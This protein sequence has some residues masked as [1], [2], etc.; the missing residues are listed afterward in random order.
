M[1]E[2]N[3]NEPFDWDIERVVK[4]L[5]TPERTWDAPA[6]HKL[7]DPER[8]A[9][10]LRDLGVDGETL[11]TYADE[12]GWSTFWETLGIKRAAHH[13]SISKAIKHFRERSAKYYRQKREIDLPTCP[14]SATPAIKPDPLNHSEPTPLVDRCIP[15]PTTAAIDGL[16]SEPS[17]AEVDSAVTEASPATVGNVATEASP[18]T[19]NSTSAEASPAVLN[20]AT[21]EPTA[22]VVSRPP[23]ETAPVVTDSPAVAPTPMEGVISQHAAPTEQ[24]QDVQM[25]CIPDQPPGS[26]EQRVLDSGLRQDTEEPS[27]DSERPPKRRR[28]APTIVSTATPAQART[29]IPTEGDMF[30]DPLLDIPSSQTGASFRSVTLPTSTFPSDVNFDWFLDA[31]V[32][33]FSY[34]GSSALRSEDI[35]SLPYNFESDDDNGGDGNKVIEEFN[36]V[37]PAAVPPAR[38][39]QVARVMRKFFRKRS[40]SV[41]EDEEV[42]LDFGED[43]DGMSVDSETYREYEE[44]EKERKARESRKKSQELGKDQAEEAI[45]DAIQKLEVRWEKVKRP[46]FERRAWKLWQDARRSRTRERHIT[47]AKNQLRSLEVRLRSIREELLDQ[48]WFKEDKIEVKAEGFLEESVYDRKYQT[49]LI[50]LLKNP[51][52]PPKP[53]T[54]PRLKP[55]P[56]KERE[57]L[58]SDEELLTSDSEEEDQFIEDDISPV[59]HMHIDPKDTNPSTRPSTPDRLSNPTTEERPTNQMPEEE[60]DTPAQ[61]PA[62]DDEAGVVSKVEPITPQR[63]IHTIPTEPIEILSSPADVDQLAN[64]PPLTDVDT[65]GQYGT[66]FWAKHR[67]GERLVIAALWSW[68][69]SRQSEIFDAVQDRGDKAIWKEHIQPLIDRAA[70]GISRIDVDPDS[71]S[72]ILALLFLTYS[73]FSEGRLKTRSTTLRCVTCQKLNREYP[74]F[75]EFFNLLQSCVRYFR[76]GAKSPTPTEM[77]STEAPEA[78]QDIPLDIASDSENLYSDLEELSSQFPLSSAKKGRRPKHNEKAKKLRVDS[79][80]LLKQMDERRKL[81]RAKLAETGSLPSDKSRLIINETKE[82]D[83]LPLIYVHE[84]IGRRIKDHQIDGVRF[85]WD[86]IVVESNSRQ[87]CLLAHTMGLGKTMQVIT[88][89]VAIA[90]ASQSDD[91]RIVAQIPKDLRVGRALILCPAGL[92]ENWIDEINIWAPEHILGKI[93]MIDAATV[94]ALGR[95]V[96]IKEWAR[97][98]GVLVMGYEMFRSLVSGKDDDVAELLQ[99]SPSIVVCDEAHRFKNKTSKLYGAVQDFKTMSRIA[100]TGSPLTKN[101]M[102]YYSMINWVAPNYLSD[103]GEFNQKYAEPISVGLHVDSTDSEKKLARER[104]QILKAIVAPKVNRKDIQVLVDELPQKKEFILTIQMTKVQRDAYKEYLETAERNKGNDLYRNVCVWGLIA[105]LKLLLAH[106][107]IFKS[108]VEERLSTNPALG[109]RKKRIANDE[110]PDSDENDEPLDLSGDMLRSVLAKVSIRGIDDI[111]HSTKVIVLLQIIKECKKIGDKVLVFSQSIPTLNFLQHLFKGRMIRYKRLDGKTPVNQRQ[112]ATKDFNTDDSLDVY[113]ISTRAGGVGLNIPGANRVVLF[114]FGFTPAEEQQAVGRAYRI[115]Q[116]KEVFVYH[117]KVGGTY[118]TAIHNLAVFKR[119]LSERVVDKKKPIPSSTRMR[120]Y[121]ITPPENLAQKDLSTVKGLDPDVLD[122]VLASA[123]C[124]N[125][126]REIDSTETFEREEVYEFT[127]EQHQEL[128]KQIELEELRINNPE[129]YKRRMYPNPEFLLPSYPPN[130]GT[131]ISA[132]VPLHLRDN[133]RNPTTISPSAAN[134][135]SAS[136]QADAPVL[137]VASTVTASQPVASLPSP[138]NG[139]VAAL[140][141]I[142]GANT[143]YKVAEAPRKPEALKAPEIIPKPRKPED[144]TKLLEALGEVHRKLRDEGYDTSIHPQDL[145]MQINSECERQDMAAGTLPRMDKLLRLCREV[146]ESSRFGEALLTG[147]LTPCEV[148][149]MSMAQMKDKIAEYEAMT[150]DLFK[151]KTWEHHRASHPPEPTADVTIK[152]EKPKTRLPIAQL[153]AMDRIATSSSTSTVTPSRTST[154]DIERKKKKKDKKDRREKRKKKRRLQPGGTADMPLVIDDD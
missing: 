151:Q 30:Y 101:V 31:E 71:I 140:D 78:T 63:L 51:H 65:I 61:I 128:N 79:K 40:P 83:D 87:G 13:L 44:E 81:L 43:D 55:G 69:P 85:M 104:L 21:S 90:E 58:A 121:F 109:N 107:K 144:T 130:L 133:K 119:Q 153:E 123:E 14:P 16:I 129:E 152:T 84:R 37:R 1:A 10:Q 145:V 88:L 139:Q 106:P 143:H 49:W 4:E 131:P 137:R 20:D 66:D 124:S 89:L 111:V 18:V 94:S 64:L 26:P 142:L 91:P 110:D 22:G 68:S 48:T 24:A 5:C 3:E 117:L 39:L 112:A 102:D 154:E 50:V 28:I 86:Q 32:P 147:Y 93:T 150:E 141:P 70:T 138:A 135:I 52:E 80:A 103:V 60:V 126:I 118:E 72:L 53:S 35:T 100:T 77:T 19:V 7:P 148:V 67:D 74:R 12:F 108:R 42:I 47:F 98:R 59:D 134:N 57:T 95:I 82:S 46:K 97:S 127:P 125:V 73:D 75:E 15:E 116:R 149:S 96:L 76:S 62:G 33:K 9:F 34:L 122:N 92:V 2:L 17:P 114:D 8:L 54:L 38:A 45:Q 136:A 41:N 27:R 25:S 120:E 115:G 29:F 113:L 146:T 132:G 36:W 56:E 105:S 23:S 6:P 11:L 99:C